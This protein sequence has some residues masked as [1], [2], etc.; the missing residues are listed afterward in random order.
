MH[1]WSSYQSRS[2]AAQDKLPVCPLEISSSATENTNL[3]MA[4]LRP[5]K[6]LLAQN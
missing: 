4:L 3:G 6:A 1:V 5:L 2:R